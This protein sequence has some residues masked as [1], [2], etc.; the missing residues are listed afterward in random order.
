MKKLLKFAAMLCLSVCIFSLYGCFGED[1]FEGL[2]V[3]NLKRSDVVGAKYVKNETGHWVPLKFTPLSEDE[4]NVE[5]TNRAWF[6][7]DEWMINEKGKTEKEELEVGDI[8]LGGGSWNYSFDKIG[9]CT[10]YVLSDAYPTH[11]RFQSLYR[12]DAATGAFSHTNENGGDLYVYFYVLGLEKKDGETY[13]WTSSNQ[14]VDCYVETTKESLM[15]VCPYD[16]EYFKDRHENAG[17]A[18]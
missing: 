15:E 9:E 6:H 10:V 18:N 16:W 11:Y 12:Y 14:C 5:V 2:D 7:I 17:G 8:M 3:T 1:S 4:F 13:L